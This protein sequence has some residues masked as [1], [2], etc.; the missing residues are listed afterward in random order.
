MVVLCCKILNVV[1]VNRALCGGDVLLLGWC[2]DMM[3]LFC[4][5]VVT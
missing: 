5:T 1:F 4:D 2:C 3:V